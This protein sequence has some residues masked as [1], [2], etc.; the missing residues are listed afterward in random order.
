MGRKSKAEWESLLAAF[1]CSRIS[2]RQFCIDK[3][4][5]L[6]GFRKQLQT[7]RQ[8]RKPRPDYQAVESTSFVMVAP[9]TYPV[10]TK[11]EAQGSAIAVT[12]VPCTLLVERTSDPVALRLAL[13]AVVDTCGR[14]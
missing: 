2:Q 1:E 6:S 13:Q 9:A 4:I 5:R 11:A 3:G 7:W 12:L 8:L 14:T 10:I